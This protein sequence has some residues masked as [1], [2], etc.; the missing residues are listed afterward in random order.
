M[1][2]QKKYKQYKQQRNISNEAKQA[3]ILKSKNIMTELKNS[4]ETYNIRFDQAEE[5]VNYKIGHLKWSRQRSKKKRGW[6]I[7][8]K[9]YINYG[10]H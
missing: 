7:V 3:E 9:V 5:L 2:E 8:K 4:I 10:Y 1:H 6:K